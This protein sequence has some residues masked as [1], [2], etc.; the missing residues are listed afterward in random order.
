[1]D[2]CVECL[3]DPSKWDCPDCESLCREKAGVPSP[4]LEEFRT[5]R[6]ADSYII[7]ALKY[8]LF[9]EGAAYETCVH[10]GWPGREDKFTQ[11]HED[12]E[13]GSC[14]SCQSKAAKEGKSLCS[15]DCS[16]GRRARL[17]PR[18]AAPDSDS[19]AE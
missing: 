12:S 10:C 6:L 16:D 1:V 13:R 3:V 2:E 14:E 7:E 15:L 18:E 11:C 9:R 8:L 19:E 5:Q 17:P 4:P